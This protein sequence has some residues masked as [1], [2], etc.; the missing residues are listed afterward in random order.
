MGRGGAG[1][2]KGGRQWAGMGEGWE[3]RRK[4]RVVMVGEG[5]EGYTGYRWT[6]CGESE[7]KAEKQGGS[8]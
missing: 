2:G 6:G 1:G 8:L 7:I 3:Q 5:A 4:A